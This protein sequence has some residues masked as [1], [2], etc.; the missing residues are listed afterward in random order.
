M[1]NQPMLRDVF[2][3]GRKADLALVSVGDLA[4]ANTMLAVGLIGNKDVASLRD[5]GVWEISAAT[6]SMRQAPRLTIRSIGAS[7]ASRPRT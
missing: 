2:E 6:G 5:A 3:R 7:S 4:E 1:M